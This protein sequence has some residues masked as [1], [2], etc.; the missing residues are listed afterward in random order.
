MI[1]LKVPFN[2]QLSLR[3]KIR[4]FE[5]DKSWGCELFEYETNV[6]RYQEALNSEWN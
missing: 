5:Q 1:L 6:V 2:L 3:F 4:G